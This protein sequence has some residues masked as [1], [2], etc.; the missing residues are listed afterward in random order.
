MA[1]IIIVGTIVL[2]VVV[3]YISDWSNEKQTE[4]KIYQ[5][6]ANRRNNTD[7]WRECGVEEYYRKKWLVPLHRGY[8]CPVCGK[9]Q[10]NDHDSDCEKCYAR[11]Q[12]DQLNSVFPKE[13][14]YPSN[15][16]FSDYYVLRL[17][18]S[19]YKTGERSLSEAQ[20]MQKSFIKD[21]NEREQ[22]KMRQRIADLDEEYNVSYRNSYLT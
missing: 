2:L 10:M 3:S 5:Q 7:D 1:I 21:V 22:R 14:L 12:K 20:E 13:I 15:F 18:E 19:E 8:K 9:I 11:Y 17:I 16:Y 6:T 4:A